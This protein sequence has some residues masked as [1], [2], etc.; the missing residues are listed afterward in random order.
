MGLPW[1]TQ[2]KVKVATVKKETYFSITTLKGEGGIGLIELFGADCLKII[3]TIFR[4][5]TGR[6]TLEQSRQGP[7]QSRHKKFPR[8]HRLYLGY[9]YN[10]NQKIDEV[11]VH[12]VPA[13][14][15]LTGLNTIE[16][17]AHGGIMSCR[18]IGN[19]LRN[20]CVKE[21]SSDE[22]TTLGYKKGGLD[23]IRKEAIDNLLG[24]RT[25]LAAG[26]LVDQYRGILS[27]TLKTRKDLYKLRESALYGL[28]M[29]QPKRILIIG[30]PNVGKSTLFN[31]LVGKER[32][33]THHIAGT[34]RDSIEE[35]ISING[36]PFILMDTAGLR[37]IKPE[38]N[39]AVI[40]KMGIFYAKQ[41]ISKANLILLVIE[42]NP[43]LQM[44]D[45]KLQV[46][47]LLSEIRKPKRRFDNRKYI[48][49]LNKI[50]LLTNS[51]NQKSTHIDNSYFIPV[52]AKTGMGVNKLT[53][54]I[55]KILGLDKFTYKSGT[56]I[57]FT[58]RQY[59]LLRNKTS[60]KR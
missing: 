16:I 36:F 18:L 8:P 49:I 6:A 24:A 17:N 1:S 35:P 2:E 53:E 41:E 48:M 15:S 12:F 37:K 42:A 30:R 51:L 33:I 59:S 57:I 38:S 13:R 21:L 26:I 14:E 9:I 31:V 40:E 60:Q 20:V 19:L 45:Y 32:A 29:T 7:L 34:T 46:D 5:L 58:P 43:F 4:P 47:S 54:E 10:E 56:P 3:E 52:S 28:S 50:D 44:T 27:K 25:P 23:I 39:N 22:V 55:L 11:I